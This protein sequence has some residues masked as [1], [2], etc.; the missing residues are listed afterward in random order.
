MRICHRRSLWPLTA[1]GACIIAG[2]FLFILLLT[3]TGC[4]VGFSD[5]GPDGKSE[6]VFGAGL[7]AV[8]KLAND[9]GQTARDFITSPDGLAAIASGGGILGLVGY[10]G[11]RVARN[12]A[13]A[14]AAEAKRIGERD[15]WDEAIADA[16]HRT[17]ARDAAF[18]EGVARAAGRVV[19]AGT[20]DTAR[21]GPVLLGRNAG[22]VGA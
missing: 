18:D 16:T 20:V 13:A 9:W 7:G 5:P 10:L 4:A 2:V 17:L 11:R 8:A 12:G 3:V 1:G 22:E 19:P 15:G 21:P 6:V 14:A